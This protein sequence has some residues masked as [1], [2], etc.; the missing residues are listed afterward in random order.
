MSR[1]V[2]IK[3]RKEKVWE[4]T[5]DLCN[6][7]DK[8]LFVD[9]DNVSS[10]QIAQLRRDFRALSAVMINGKN[11]VMKK[12]ITEL[13]LEDENKGEHRPHL[14][15]IKNNLVNNTGLIFTDGDLL[16]IKTVIEKNVRGAPAKVGA[17]AP[18]DVVVPAGDTGL[19]VRFTSFFQAAGIATKVVKSKV[20]IQ[21]PFKVC[22]A[23]E[24][25]TPGAAAVLDKLNIRPFE[26]AMAIKGFCMDGQ[27]YPA[28][29]LSIKPE[30]ILDTFRA[31]ATNVTAAALGC[32]YVTSQSVEHLIAAAMQNL[33]S[34]SVGCGLTQ[35][36]ENDAPALEEKVEVKEAAKEDPATQ[37]EEEADF[38]MVG[39]FDDDY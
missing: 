18:A 25:I 5:Q 37:D 20:N 11:T 27:E 1:Q 34:V 35:I 15:I 32:G 36:A 31:G 17:I 16:E 29:V 8:C 7:Y 23:G 12:A 30:Q 10:L 9:V 38:D 6:T 2:Q 24:K 21:A 19:E 13:Q 26:Y 33:I 14:E 39:M 28:H 22:V 3:Q 4:T